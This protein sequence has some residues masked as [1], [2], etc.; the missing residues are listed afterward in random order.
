MVSLK[1][2]T[3]FQTLVANKAEGLGYRVQRYGQQI[4]VTAPR[5]EFLTVLQMASAPLG[6]VLQRADDLWEVLDHRDRVMAYVTTAYCRQDELR[7]NVPYALLK[8][9]EE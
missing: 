3:V 7:V 5:A 4:T 9:R 2:L 8:S 6:R 1:R